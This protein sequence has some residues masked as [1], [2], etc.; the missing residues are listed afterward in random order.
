MT[1]YV[2]R[3]RDEW[4]GWVIAQPVIAALWVYSF[5]DKEERVISR[6]E[7][8]ESPYPDQERTVWLYC[9]YCQADAWHLSITWQPKGNKTFECGECEQVSE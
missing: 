9:D 5:F 7:Y 4:L 2:P 8:R 3:Q 1:M 6:H